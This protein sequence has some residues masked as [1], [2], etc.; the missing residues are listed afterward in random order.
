MNQIILVRFKVER[1]THGSGV[2][3]KTQ[4]DAIYLKSDEQE[5]DFK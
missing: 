1:A 5:C 2:F 4:Y 3:Q